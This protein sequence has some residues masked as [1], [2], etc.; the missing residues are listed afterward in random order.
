MDVQPLL[1]GTEALASEGV[2]IEPERVLIRVRSTQ[3]WARCPDCHDPAQAYT[4]ATNA[5]RPICRCCARRY[6]C[7]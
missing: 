2:S 7:T 5:R 3:P 4:A 6:V 1:P